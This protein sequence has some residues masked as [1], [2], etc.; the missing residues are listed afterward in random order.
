VASGVF[1]IPDV[2]RIPESVR[3]TVMGRWEES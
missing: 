3:A 2:D 1:K